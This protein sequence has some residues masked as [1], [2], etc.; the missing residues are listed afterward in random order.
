MVASG[1]LDFRALAVLWCANLL[2]HLPAAAVQAASSRG[3]LRLEAF[4]EQRGAAWFLRLDPSGDL[5]VN[6]RGKVH[7]RKIDDATLRQLTELIR[8]ERIF[9]LGEVY[10]DPIFDVDW[11]TVTIWLEGRKKTFS[12]YVD[13]PADAHHDEVKRALRLWVAI[14]DLFEIP[15]AADSRDADRK[16]LAQ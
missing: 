15:E 11:R 6:V 1:F 8:R 3:D 12:L 9:E 14:R 7:K 13:L 16:L 4:Q 10:G 5:T 2:P